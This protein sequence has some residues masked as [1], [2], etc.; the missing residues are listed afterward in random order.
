MPFWLRVIAYQNTKGN[1]TMLFIGVKEIRVT[2]Y[3]V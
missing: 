2:T 1:T 3:K